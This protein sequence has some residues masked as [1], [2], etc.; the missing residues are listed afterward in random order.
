MK[1]GDPHTSAS[2]AGICN[3]RNNLT[4]GGFAGF[5]GGL[6]F[7]GG[8]LRGFGE[9]LRGFRG[10]RGVWEVWGVGRGWRV[11]GVSRTL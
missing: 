10:V 9:V 1:A 2:K 7:S 5:W 3:R 4:L 6:G 8:F 11:L